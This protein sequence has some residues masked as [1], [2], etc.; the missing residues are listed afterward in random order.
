MLSLKKELIFFFVNKLDDKLR[1]QRMKKIMKK[2][3]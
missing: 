2:I 1:Y 3:F